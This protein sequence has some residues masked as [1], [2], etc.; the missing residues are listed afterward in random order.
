MLVCAMDRKH[1]AR[2]AGLLQQLCESNP[3][4]ERFRIQEIYNDTEAAHQRIEQLKTDRTDIVVSVR[5]IS[6]G[7]DVHRFR[8]WL[9]RNQH[10]D[11]D[12]LQA[13]C[14]AFRA[15]GRAARPEPVRDHDHP[16]AC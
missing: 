14:R 11:P 3:D 15:L 8:G 10:T 13:V 12:V 1:G 6:E 5:M 4:W 2:V 7:I 9:V 16:G